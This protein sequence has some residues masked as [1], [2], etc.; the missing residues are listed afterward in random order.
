MQQTEKI[1]RAERE[2][3]KKV[4]NHS[5]WLSVTLFG[6]ADATAVAAA[7]LNVDDVDK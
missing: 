6:T 7:S 5:E 1:G 2:R 3:E 4:R